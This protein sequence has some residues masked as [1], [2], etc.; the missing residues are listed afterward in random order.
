[1]TT[2]KL[3]VIFWVL[4][5]VSQPPSSLSKAAQLNQYQLS[6][7]NMMFRFF[8]ILINHWII[9]SF[10]L[11]WNTNIYYWHTISSVQIQSVQKSVTV[12]PIFFLKS[13]ERMH[14]HTSLFVKQTIYLF[15]SLPVW[16]GLGG[17]GGVGGRR[18]RRRR[19]VFLNGG[20]KQRPLLRPA[21]CPEDHLVPGYPTPLFPR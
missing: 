20:W 12:I 13:T 15:F 18:R 5:F 17:D 14:T 8:K 19:W 9:V 4:E 16:P 2:L 21:P 6:V 1:M 3:S 7:N 11:W 10:W